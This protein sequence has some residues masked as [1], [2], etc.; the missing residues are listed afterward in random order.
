MNT[1]DLENRIKELERERDKY[2]MLARRKIRERNEIALE[3][4]QLKAAIHDF[5]RAAS[6]VI[7]DSAMAY[8]L[9]VVDTELPEERKG[10][11]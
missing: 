6:H 5:C 7:D 8:A 2:E 3:N 10:A 11:S 9:G 4:T 1:I